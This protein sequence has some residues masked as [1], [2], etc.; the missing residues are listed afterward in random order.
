MNQEDDERLSAIV[1]STTATNLPTVKQPRRSAQYLPG[2]WPFRP[3][4][5]AGP[6]KAGRTLSERRWSTYCGFQMKTILW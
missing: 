1:S 5:P 3:P 4:A 6:A 2:S